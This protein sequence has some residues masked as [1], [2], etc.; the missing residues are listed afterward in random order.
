[1]FGNAIGCWPSLKAQANLQQDTC[2]FQR[3]VVL[4]AEHAESLI[5]QWFIPIITMT[6]LSLGS[7]FPLPLTES[8]NQ[9]SH[10][11]LHAGSV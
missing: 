4:L 6:A 3:D 7:R 11:M 9:P 10:K 2:L 5:P 1:M 8:A